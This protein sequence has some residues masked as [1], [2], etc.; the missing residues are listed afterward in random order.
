[1]DAGPTRTACTKFVIDV[2]GDK[3]IQNSILR[4]IVSPDFAARAV[5]WADSEGGEAPQLVNATERDLL[6]SRLI[7]SIFGEN[8]FGEIIC[9]YPARHRRRTN[10]GSKRLWPLN[11]RVNLPG[12]IG[13]RGSPKR[14]RMRA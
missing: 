10:F 12:Y 9:I 14:P 1:V 5:A 6:V 4:T 11:L 3:V 8:D 7:G 2:F 13:H